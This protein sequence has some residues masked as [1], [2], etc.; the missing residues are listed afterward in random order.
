[1]LITHQELQN[2]NKIQ[3]DILKNVSDA[4]KILNIK[5]FVVH[6]TLLGTIKNKKFIPDD[7]DIDIAM[8]RED[9]EIFIK[10]ASR[11][12]SQRY[13][14]QTNDTDMNYPLTF[15]KI[16]DTLTTYIV[17]ETKNIKM[18]HG[19]YIDVFPI[20]Y[21]SENK[22]IRI[23]K[24]IIIKILDLRITY[25]F[26]IK[27]DSIV[28]KCIRLICCLL[29]PSYNKAIKIRDKLNKNIKYSNYICITGGKSTEKFIPKEW[30]NTFEPNLFE[31]IPVFVPFLYDKYLRRI[32]GDY[33]NRTL[34]ENKINN[35]KYIEVNA[36]IINTQKSY[37]EY[38]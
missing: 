16:R 19:I 38:L 21:C 36:C 3:L 6:G 23:I 37:S 10:N 17:D 22:I 30:F 9:Y 33:I 1:M 14:I 13:F 27:K 32:Y 26:E 20:D 4:C 7:D 15:G 35:E 12:L 8:F 34:I 2:I 11:I 31:N 25:I 24:N 29:I 18:N 5:F 28:K